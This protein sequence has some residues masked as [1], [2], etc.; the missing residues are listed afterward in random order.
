MNI[1]YIGSGFVGTCS[2]A[3][4]A[5]SG[6]QTMLYDIDDRK[7]KLLG[8]GDRAQIES[9]LFEDGLADLLIR[10][11]ERLRFTSVYEDVEQF[12]DSCDAIFLCLPTP[13][14][15]E[16]GESDLQYYF[17]ATNKLAAALAK[18]NDGRQEKYLLIINKSTVPIEMIDRTQLLLNEAGVRECGVVS[19]PEFLVEG[20]AVEGS[21]R[22][23]RVVVG[24]W[25]KADFKIMRQ[26]YQRFYESIKIEYIEVNPKEAAAGKLVANFYLFNKLAV[27]FDVIGR[28]TETFSQL[29]FENIRR[30]LTSDPRIG[31]WGF[32][33][34]LYAGGSC[35][36]KDARSLSYQLQTAGQKAT[37]INETYLANK[38][39]LELFLAR[40]EQEAGFSWAGATVALL[41][42]SFK[43]NTNDIRNS[44]SID[45]V[46]CLL[47]KGVKKFQLYDPVARPEFE[48]LFPA[49]VHLAYANDEE[50][51]LARAD[52]VLIATDW[53]Q[54]RNLPD[55]YLL[56]RQER[57]LIMDGRRIL[58]HSY[59][60]LQK[61]GFNIIAVGSPFIKAL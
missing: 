10:N 15:G 30:I 53:Q 13:E 22:P 61:N 1:L 8:S 11:T 54:F 59:E 36:I 12:L 35:F 14:I 50:E 25:N 19:N 33:D 42:L 29:G 57:P 7:I 28:T 56:K 52:V 48:H 37:L 26:L 41:G 18:R 16:T 39:Q 23:V 34:S 47:A 38:R 2:A 21:I 3:I 51:A 24:A 4:T 31:S 20:Q 46:H 17:A 45:I 58:V 49:S 55:K 32:Y 40:P 27:C 5:D 60:Q 9:C 6:H 44:P 43:Q